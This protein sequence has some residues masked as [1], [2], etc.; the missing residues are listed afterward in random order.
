MMW[1]VMMKLMTVMSAVEME[2][3]MRIIIIIIVIV[4]VITIAVA[5][6]VIISE[7]ITV[8]IYTNTV[9]LEMPLKF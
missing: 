2:L 8:N 1:T 4:I 7:F 6:N 5:A 3:M 9:K